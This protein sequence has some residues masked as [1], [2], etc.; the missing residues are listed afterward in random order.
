M[1]QT[2]DHIPMAIEPS[3]N[4]SRHLPSTELREPI[5]Q[6]I[7]EEIH[8][9]DYLDVIFRRK[10][11]ILGLLLMTFVSTL[12]FSLA[13]Q[14]LYRAEGSLE[15]SMDSQRLTK[16]EDVMEQRVRAQEFV[17]TQVALLKSNTVAQRVIEYL[18]LKEHPLITSDNDADDEGITLGSLKNNMAAWVRSFIGKK[19]DAMPTASDNPLILE[20]LEDKRI[21]E[22]FHD[23]LEVSPG[24]DSMIVNIAFLSPSR[25]LSR[26]I[27]NHL[28]M[29]YINWKMDQRVDSSSKAREYLMKQID[30][31]KINLEEAEEK[32]HQ[33]A[34]EAGI[35]S[36]DSRLNS[37][38]RQLEDIT[39]E[40]GNAEADFISKKAQYEQALQDG[41]NS[42][43][44]VLNSLMINSLK[45]EYAK[46]RSDYENL[47][48]I[49]HEDYPDVKTIRSRMISIDDRIA[50]ESNKIFNAIRHDYLS[51]KNRFETLQKNMAEKTQQALELN[52]RAT[53]YQIMAREVETNKAIYQSLL[54]RTKEIESMAGI[55]PSN[56][57]IVDMASLPI[58]PA[59]PNIKRNL[60]LAIVLGLMCGIGMAFMMEYFADT[61][62]NPD[63][64]TER[65]NIPILGVIPLETSPQDHPLEHIFVNDP[66]SNMSEAMRTTRVSIQLSGSDSNARC[67]AI[68]STEPGEGKTTIAANLAHTFAGAGEKV[69]IIDA[70]LRKPRL[71]KVFPNVASTGN[72]HGLSSFLAGITDNGIVLKTHVDNLCLIVSGPIPPNP[73]ELLASGRFERLLKES[74]NEFDRIII[75]CPPHMGFADILVISRQ[76]GGMILVSGI[77]ETT[78]DG[79]RN[80]KKAMQN[81]NGT[82]LGCIVNKVNLN[83]RYGY[84]S[85]YKYYKAYHYD[86]G[87]T[88]GSS[89]RGLG[90]N[91]TDKIAA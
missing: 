13:A 54:E 64:I 26:D 81:V 9:R 48:E 58:F 32:Q 30:R 65:F 31:A 86:Y 67:I 87:Q 2:S 53:Q 14:K 23:N 61:I 33:F 12:I 28:M 63:Q 83:Q 75:D 15:M 22:F 55:A 71:H 24:R 25:E 36:M 69:L 60:L 72:G 34:R 35:V 39:A 29:E 5:P 3:G 52:E 66:R 56:V 42:L 47:S 20:S 16:F 40:L 76:V 7:E 6:V 19:E 1:T 62:T 74:A 90:G 46:L 41:P 68:T 43:P 11:L 10:W 8:L 89:E 59:K 18:N 49:F 38:F 73:V 21:L 77:G 44:Q 70:D 79:V 91:N 88:K 57:Q 84:R 80:F 51:A 82:I 45:T 50:D 37:V 78:R 4:G 17:T 85:Y 27:V